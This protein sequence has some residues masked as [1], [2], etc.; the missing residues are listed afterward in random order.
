MAKTAE[1]VLTGLLSTSYKLDETGVAALK[2][3]DGSFKDDSTDHLLKLDAERVATLRG[4]PEKLKAENYSRGKREALEALEKELKEEFGV[5]ASDVKGTALIK[6]IIAEK[7]G[8]ANSDLS[9]DKIKA[10][11]LYRELEE[12]MQTKEKSFEEKLKE[13][14]EKLRSEFNS[15]RDTESVLDQA[16]NLFKGMKPKLPKNE[17][18]A[19][20]QMSLLENFVKGHKFQL[21]RDKEGKVTDIVPMK[22]DGSG[23]LEDQH[24]HAVKFDDLIR[25]GARKFYE[26]EDGER[27]LGAPDPGRSGGSND[28]GDQGG[29]YDPKTVS[30]YAKLFGEIRRSYEGTERIE[31]WKLLKEAGI[32]NGVVS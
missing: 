18:V 15:V 14:E 30:E 13:H 24:G 5:K 20:N 23:R 26:F 21:T 31:Q 28:T 22:E 27:K 10:S 25:A 3:A 8:T 4:D 29:A 12:H 7:A 19:A 1:E 2:E 16:K 9:D 17:E 11:K 32:K 6:H